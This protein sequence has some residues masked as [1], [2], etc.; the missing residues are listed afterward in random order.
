[1]WPYSVVVW[2]SKVFLE[3]FSES[4]KWRTPLWRFCDS[5][6]VYMN[7]L[8][9]LTYLLCSKRDECVVRQRAAENRGE[10]EQR[11]HVLNS[12]FSSRSFK[13]LDIRTSSCARKWHWRSIFRSH[14]FRYVLFFC[15][16]F[17]AVKCYCF[18]C[19]FNSTVGCLRGVEM[20]D[21][22]VVHVGS[23]PGEVM[24]RHNGYSMWNDKRETHKSVTF[25]HLF[26]LF[27]IQQ[28]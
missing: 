12:T 4:K 3:N 5:G 14:V 18:H 26:G 10:N 22:P 16:Q 9:L 17:L 27:H 25:L 15:V 11:F 28:T 19:E 6:A 7:D 1:V 13:R 8:S 23:S 2:I 21:F 24:I 20:N